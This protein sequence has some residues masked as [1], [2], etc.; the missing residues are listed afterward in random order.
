M[1]GAATGDATVAVG[2]PG[3]GPGDKL[4]V[5]PGNVT[6][7]PIRSAVQMVEVQQMLM[8]GMSGGPLLDLNDQVIGVVHKGGHEHGRQLAIDISVLHAWRP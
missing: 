7:M 3:F 8:Q 6:S 5:R 4:N 1:K 2:Y